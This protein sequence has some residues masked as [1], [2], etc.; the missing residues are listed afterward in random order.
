MT[1]QTR[2]QLSDQVLETLV[3]AI[4]DF[5]YDVGFGE[6]SDVTAKEVA[7]RM[8]ISVYAVNGALGHLEAKGLVQQ[9]VFGDGSNCLQAASDEVRQ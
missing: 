7:L 5:G 8:G 9:D 6:Y 4:I 2:K 3:E 1:D